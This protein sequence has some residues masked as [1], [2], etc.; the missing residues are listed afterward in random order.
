MDAKEARVLSELAKP[1]LHEN[2][3]KFI[4]EHISKAASKGDRTTIVSI[5][6]VSTKLHSEIVRYMKSKGYEARISSDTRGTVNW[7]SLVLK[8]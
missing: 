6:E 1:K 8:W 5:H 4:F 7:H 3:I 2:L